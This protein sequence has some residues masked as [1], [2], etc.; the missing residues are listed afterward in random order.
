[1]KKILALFFALGAITAAFAQNGLS[2]DESRDVI[3]GKENNRTVYDDRR[4]DGRY[5]NRDNDRYGKNE[6]ED[7]IAII[8]REFDWKIESLK[9]DRYLK[10]GEKKRR[11]RALENERDDR[12]REARQRFYDDRNYR[13]SR[14]Y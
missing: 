12:V 7:R 10:N 6:L 2:R 13:N 1:M 8:K 3:L 11:V 14:R 4:D 9:R 5:E